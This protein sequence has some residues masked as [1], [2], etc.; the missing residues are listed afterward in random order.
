MSKRTNSPA[1]NAPD[2]GSFPLDHFQECDTIAEEYRLC[3]EN[4]SNIPKICK[5]QAMRYL[6]CRMD[7]GLMANHSMEELGFIPESTW[8]YEQNSK[9]ELLFKISK[10]MR[11]SKERVR[12]EYESKK[13]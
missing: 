10:I 2:K 1:P 13:K 5:E 6:Q 7:K 8:E 3:V 4:A 11:E 12:K 9:T